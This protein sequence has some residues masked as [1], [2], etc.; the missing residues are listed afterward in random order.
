MISLSGIRRGIKAFFNKEYSEDTL[1]IEEQSCF[2]LFL[3][4]KIFRY[5]NEACL[6]YFGDNDKYRELIKQVLKDY[7]HLFLREEAMN[8]CIKNG[9]DRNKALDAI[10]LESSD[11][12]FV[13][14][15]QKVFP[16]LNLIKVMVKLKP[17]P[18]F[19]HGAVFKS[20][21]IDV[22]FL[23][24]DENGVITIVGDIKQ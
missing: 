7:H 10:E 2:F 3:A 8:V 15:F 16:N 20:D 4:Y 1:T 5:C 9:T 19:K 18:Q 6:K 22:L 24:I 11:K 12:F 21:A 14:C 23:D 17:K 13:D